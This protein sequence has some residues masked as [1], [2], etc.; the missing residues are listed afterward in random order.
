MSLKKI[1]NDQYDGVKISSLKD[2]NLFN[3]EVESII[4]TSLN[5]IKKS[6]KKKLTILE[7]G[8]GSGE[9]IRRMDKI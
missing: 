4:S 3:K 7:L 8:C 5:F 2:I 6:K 1:W 9:L